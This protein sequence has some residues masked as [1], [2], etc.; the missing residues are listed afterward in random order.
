MLKGLIGKKIGMTQI[1]D[2]NGAAVPVTL[3]EAGPCFVTLVRSVEK[4]GYSAVQLGFEEVK[5]KRLTGGEIGH[6]KRVNLPPLKFLRE[7]KAKDTELKEGDKLDVS[8]FALGEKV[9]VSGTSKGKGFAGAV[10]RYHFRGG[11]KTHGA[12]DRLRAPGSNGATTTPGRVYKGHRGPGHMGNDSV[13]AQNLKVVLVDAE[14]NVIGVNGSVP[15]ARGGLVVI[16]E[17]RKQ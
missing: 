6:L 10:K 17:S 15:G 7:F 9:D 2:D 4:D 1:F 3:I 5:P 8:V 14:R 13:T 16:K 12:S 11:P